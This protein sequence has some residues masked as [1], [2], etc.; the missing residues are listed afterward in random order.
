MIPFGAAVA[1]CNVI[2]KRNEKEDKKSAKLRKKTSQ[3]ELN[4]DDDNVR[5]NFNVVQDFDWARAAWAIINVCKE[6][7]QIENLKQ[8]ITDNSLDVN[9]DFYKK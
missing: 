7:G 8:I 5:L 4:I 3:I 1:A 2:R 6:K 9:D